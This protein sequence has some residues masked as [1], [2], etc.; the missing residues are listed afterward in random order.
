MPHKFLCRGVFSR[1]Q[2]QSGA[3]AR[4][5]TADLHFM[6]SFARAVSLALV[7]FSREGSP[8]GAAKW[9]FNPPKPTPK[10]QVRIGCCRASSS[11]SIFMQIVVG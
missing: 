10:Q 7:L 6:S 3:R 9:P 8:V 11:I 5:N 2:R 4:G 1:L